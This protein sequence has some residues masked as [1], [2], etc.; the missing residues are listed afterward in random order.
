LRLDVFFPTKEVQIL[1]D[2]VYVHFPFYEERDVGNAH[3]N[4]RDPF[5]GKS[6]PVFDSATYVEYVWLRKTTGKYKIKLASSG[7]YPEVKGISPPV[8]LDKLE[9]NTSG[10]RVILY[11]LAL[12]QSKEFHLSGKTRQCMY[13]AIATK[14]KT[15][16]VVKPSNTI[17]ISSPL[18]L[19]FP[20]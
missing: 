3:E 4:Y 6:E 10:R 8:K 1:D 19:T 12:D 2:F 18:Y 9:P 14:T 20:P 16:S 13:I 5:T 11:N 15:P 7:L 17:R